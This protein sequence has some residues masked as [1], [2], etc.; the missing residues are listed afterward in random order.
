MSLRGRTSGL[1]DWHRIKVHGEG[2][3]LGASDADWVFWNGGLHVG[4]V[5]GLSCSPFQCCNTFESTCC[6]GTIGTPCV[7]ILVSFPTS[8][9]PVGHALAATVVILQFIVVSTRY[10]VFQQPVC[11]EAVRSRIRPDAHDTV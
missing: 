10:F 4:V 1:D 2:L 7:V 6:L 5:C 8:V 11:R 9:D 3:D